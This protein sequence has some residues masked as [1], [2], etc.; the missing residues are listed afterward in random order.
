MLTCSWLTMTAP[1]ARAISPNFG[2]WNS[3]KKLLK[4]MTATCSC[5]HS[6]AIGSAIGSGCHESCRQLGQLMIHCT[7]STSRILSTNSIK[8]THIV[9]SFTHQLMK[10]SRAF[11]SPDPAFVISS[12]LS[13]RTSGL[14]S[15][16]EALC[17]QKGHCRDKL[18][19]HT[20]CWQ[21]SRCQ[22]LA[23]QFVECTPIY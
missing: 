16:K 22:M 18:R 14:G 20:S 15:A 17:C 7:M 13:I 11:L 2:R 23:R 5:V 1:I 9:I 6:S 21:L 8:S 10:T 4:A 12:S 3:L 19:L